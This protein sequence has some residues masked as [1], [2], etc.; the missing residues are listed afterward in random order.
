[1]NLLRSMLV[2]VPFVVGALLIG[3]LSAFLGVSR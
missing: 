1:M 3:F 2:A